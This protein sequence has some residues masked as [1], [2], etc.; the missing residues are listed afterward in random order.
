MKPTTCSRWRVSW[1]TRGVTH[2]AMESTGVAGSA[3]SNRW[4]LAYIHRLGA[5]RASRRAQAPG[6]EYGRRG[7]RTGLRGCRSTACC[8]HGV[9]L[10]PEP[11][12]DL[13]DRHRR[14]RGASGCVAGER[15]RTV[16]NRV[17]S[18][19]LERRQR[20]AER[21]S[22]SDHRMRVSGQAMLR[23]L[24]A[25]ADDGLRVR[26]AIPRAASRVAPEPGRAASAP[27][28]ACAR[29]HRFLLTRRR[30]SRSRFT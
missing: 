3:A 13:R 27:P 11:V 5:S 23:A 29:H 19:G 4:K 30:S 6:A 25:R 18:H 10:P 17:P 28:G 16:R 1:P 22:T 24:S 2:V 15:T 14:R 21:G 8:N 7:R 12:R 9:S 20:Q 26:V